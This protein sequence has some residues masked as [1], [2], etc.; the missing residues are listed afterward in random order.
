MERHRGFAPLTSVLQTDD[1]L[2]VQCPICRCQ[3][4]NLGQ[5]LTRQTHSHFATPAKD[6]KAI[7]FQGACGDHSTSAIPGVYL[8]NVEGNYDYKVDQQGVEPRNSDC[9]PNSLPLAY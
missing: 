7:S 1:L 5:L 2:L 8:P 3:E 9:K 6:P 4:S